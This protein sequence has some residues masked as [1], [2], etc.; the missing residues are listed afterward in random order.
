M[1]LPRI[2]AL[3]TS[4]LAVIRLD[5]DMLEN[6]VIATPLDRSRGVY[7]GMTEYSGWVLV[8]VRNRDAA[9]RVCVNNFPTDAICIFDQSTG[10]NDLFMRHPALSDLHQIRRVGS[11]LC[12]VCGRGS[13]LLI[14]S[15]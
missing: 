8:A 5:V 13:Q 1:T 12:V 15:L 14:F 6:K 4:Y 11:W 2:F 9:G 3:M 10:L 7:F